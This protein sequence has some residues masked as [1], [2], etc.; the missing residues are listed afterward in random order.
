MPSTKNPYKEISRLR[1]LIKMVAKYPLG[2]P[3]RLWQRILK[4]ARG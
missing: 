4:E 1:R 3:D 2:M